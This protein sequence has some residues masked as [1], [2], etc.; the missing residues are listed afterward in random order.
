LRESFISK[1]RDALDSDSA[2]AAR[3]AGAPNM[4]RHGVGANPAAAVGSALVAM[5]AMQIGSGSVTLR[6][7]RA[8]KR[9]RKPQAFW[10]SIAFEIVM[11]AVL[12]GG[13]ILIP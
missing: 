4:P 6:G 11:A 13:L 1:R 5:I 9:A 2:D 7:G 8:I 12:L 10:L 3:T